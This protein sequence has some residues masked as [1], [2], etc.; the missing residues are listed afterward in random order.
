MASTHIG[1]LAYLL[2]S[3]EFYDVDTMGF[4]K[5]FLVSM[6]FSLLYDLSR[7]VIDDL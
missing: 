7:R 6:N 1:I 3:I 2:A 5:N 4:L